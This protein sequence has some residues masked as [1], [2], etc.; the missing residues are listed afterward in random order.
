MNKD[1]ELSKVIITKDNNYLLLKRS[2]TSKTY[3]NTWD[4]PGGKLDTGEIPIQT[5]LREAKEETG[6][7]IEIGTEVKTHST[8]FNGHTSVFHY[9]LSESFSGNIQISNEHSEYGWFS[10]EE[11]SKLDVHPTVRVWF[12]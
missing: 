7:D 12:G 5:A 9:F 6:L 11:I 8:T 1:L 2:S 3:P 10:K 4:F